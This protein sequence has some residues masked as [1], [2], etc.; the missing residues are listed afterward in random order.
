LDQLRP[1][2][3]KVILQPRERP[4]DTL[5]AARIILAILLVCGA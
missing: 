4:T 3:H 1:V 5:D 2:L